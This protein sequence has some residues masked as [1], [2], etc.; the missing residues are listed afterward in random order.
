M[1]NDHTCKAEQSSSP[2][3]KASPRI[4]IAVRQFKEF[5]NEELYKSKPCSPLKAHLSKKIRWFKQRRPPTTQRN[6]NDEELF[7]LLPYVLKHGKYRKP[8]DDRISF[9]DRVP[10]D[11]HLS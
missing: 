4:K 10:L 7:G 5:V 3:V 2:T 11:V 8:A 9:S 1:S 6:A